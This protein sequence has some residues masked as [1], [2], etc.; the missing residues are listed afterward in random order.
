MAFDESGID[1]LATNPKAFDSG[2]RN[3]SRKE[4]TWVWVEDGKLM[5]KADVIADTPEVVY[6]EGVW[7][8]PT[9]RGKGNGFRCM[10]QLNREVPDAH[11]Q[12]LSAG[13]RDI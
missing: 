10:S 5:F 4:Q 11:S 9:E 7:V 12:R 13:Q 2:A 6:L 8:D 1:P 3:A